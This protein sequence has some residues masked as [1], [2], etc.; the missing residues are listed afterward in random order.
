M[1]SQPRFDSGKGFPGTVSLVR[2]LPPG[3]SVDVAAGYDLAVEFEQKGDAV[4]AKL[5]RDIMNGRK[6]NLSTAASNQGLPVFSLGAA[7]GFTEF[8]VLHGFIFGWN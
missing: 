2:V 3:V 1:H 7:S 8:R 4:Y 5:V 6:F